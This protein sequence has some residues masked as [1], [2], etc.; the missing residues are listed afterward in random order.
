MFTGAVV[1]W[2][3][4]TKPFSLFVGGVARSVVTA[5][6][7]SLSSSSAG[8]EAPRPGVGVEKATQSRSSALERSFITS[9]ADADGGASGSSNTRPAATAASRVRTSWAS[10]LAISTSSAV[11][12][13][14]SI[15]SKEVAEVAEEAIA[16]SGLVRKLFPSNFS[17]KLG[18]ENPR[19]KL[20]PKWPG[21]LW[22]SIS[23]TVHVSTCVSTLTKYNPP[24]TTS[25]LTSHQLEP[26]RDP[27]TVNGK[28]S[29]PRTT[30][31]SVPCLVGG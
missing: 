20:E 30:R 26:D 10:W 12:A 31:T 5:S 15:N 8:P 25:K 18:S 19:A 24:K 27:V 3:A 11:S 29:N 17:T 7:I 28:W 2:E 21:P 23:N 9:V 6:L 4:A 22:S 13:W 14:S 16:C 1:F